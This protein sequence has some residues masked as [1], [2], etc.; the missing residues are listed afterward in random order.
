MHSGTKRTIICLM[1]IGCLLLSGNRALAQ[2]T[3]RIQYVNKDSAFNPA[4]LQLQT[5]FAGQL[6]CLQY[7][8]K[9]TPLLRSKGYPTVS[10]DSIYTDTSY[11]AIQL[12]L[13]KQYQ[14]VQLRPDSLEK[15]ALDQSGYFEKDFSS[16]PLNISLLKGMQQR[17]LAHYE[18]KG[19]PF[20]AVY[21]DSIKLLD[22]KM[23]ALL[24][25]NKGPLYHID[26]IR[27]FGKAKISNFFLQ[28]YLGI[29]NGSTYNRDKLDRVSKRLLELPYLEQLQNP[30]LTMLGSGAV[31]NLYLNNKR[32]SQVNFLIGFLP[33][34]ST[35]GK[36][37]VTGDVNLNL[38]NAFGTGETL[39]FTW[40]QLQLKSPR[41]NLGY[42]KPY[43]FRSA[44]GIDFAFELFKKD[45]A[46]LQINAT[47][48]IQYLLSSNQQGRL[49]VQQQ[50]T[51]L[52]ASGA[53]TNLVKSTKKLPPNVDINTT[54]VGL[55]YE[56]N[57]T[58]YR[59]NPRTGNEIKI[60]VSTGIKKIEKNNDIL[61]LKDPLFNYAAL[62][63][64]VKLRT[65]QLRLRATLAHYFPLARQ[66]TL[67]AAF[68]GGLFASQSV[69]RNELFQIGGYRLLRGFDEESIYATQ[70]AVFTAEYR[71]IIN[72]NSY[73]FG[74]AD[75]GWVRNQ[76]QQVDVINNFIS[77]GLGLAFET[78]F[79][80]LNIS[81][82]LGR[83]NDVDF[84]LRQAAKIHFGYVNYF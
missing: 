17:M 73:L 14:W 20:A 27:V 58:N 30:D 33:A 52:L 75:A 67:K 23:L 62:Y 28:Q 26:S 1:A 54:S 34:N 57:N 65:Y 50:R 4:T 12:Y 55:D 15:E 18:K 77:A 39:L 84:N 80:Q 63:D 11:T 25:V 68:N 69:F 79:G 38:K 82:A 3:L 40:Q 59:R 64:S 19:Y 6:L 5:N 81:F 36:L 61:S 10:V 16:K 74:F 29:G 72:L 66:S 46:F 83:R 60:V 2:Y 31:L 49:F 32:S 7:V 56:W 22:D 24:K 51:S 45:S 13:G 48:G 71:N 42:Q 41:L 37:Q 9:L 35:N 70:Y 53:D 47:L 44:F 21:L 76:H 78:K 43:L 8:D